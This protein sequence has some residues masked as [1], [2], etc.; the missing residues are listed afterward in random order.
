MTDDYPTAL[1][2]AVANTTGAELVEV[3]GQTRIRI[4]AETPRGVRAIADALERRVRDHLD[5]MREAREDLAFQE[6]LDNRGI[7]HLG[8]GRREYTGISHAA[9]DC[10]GLPVVVTRKGAAF[11]AHPAHKRTD[12]GFGPALEYRVSG[13]RKWWPTTRSTGCEI[14][15]WRLAGGGQ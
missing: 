6:W 4:T 7:T 8:P 15:E 5:E 2:K 13:G 1:A 12:V 11:D 9:R 14:A 10:D 3:D